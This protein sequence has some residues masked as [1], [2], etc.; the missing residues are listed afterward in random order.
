[1]IIVKILEQ[2]RERIVYHAASAGGVL[3]PN[4]S[5]FETSEKVVLLSSPRRRGSGFREF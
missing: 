1:V 4:Q 5:C 2:R 3:H